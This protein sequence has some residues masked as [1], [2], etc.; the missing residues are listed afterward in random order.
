MSP[1]PSLCVLANDILPQMPGDFVPL[2]IRFSEKVAV[3]GDAQ[4]RQKVSPPCFYIVI[5]F[6]V[7]HG[8]FASMTFVPRFRHG[9][10]EQGQIEVQSPL[11]E[12]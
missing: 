2:V 1:L 5:K 6:E 10:F 4:Q 12:Q 3:G 11:Q 8:H 7:T 9:R